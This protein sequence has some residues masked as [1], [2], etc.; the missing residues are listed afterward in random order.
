MTDYSK[1]T[2]DD[3][4]RILN[5]LVNRSPASDLFNIPGIYELVSEDYNNMGLEY[6]QQEKETEDDD[7][8]TEDDHSV[9]RSLEAPL[10]RLIELVHRRGGILE[11]H[12]AYRATGVHNPRSLHTEGRAID[13]TCDEFSLEELAKLCWAAGFDWVYYEGGSKV[14]GP[15]IHCSV[16][17]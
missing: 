4:A 3:F 17:R 16:R 10:R 14:N 7:T 6:W 2:N 12:E 8:D 13:V 15:H 9:H 1:M 5:E 11:V